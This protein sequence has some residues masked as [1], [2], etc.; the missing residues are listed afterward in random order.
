[1]K[2]DNFSGGFDLI[3][4]NIKGS[5][6]FVFFKSGSSFFKTFLE[7][8]KH[9]TYFLVDVTNKI[10]GVYGGFERF[11]VEFSNFVVP[12]IRFFSS[13]TSVINISNI[14]SGL[15]TLWNGNTL[16][17]DLLE[18]FVYGLSFE[19]MFVFSKFTGVFTF[20]LS[21]DWSFT[22]SF[23]SSKFSS[24]DINSI[25]SVLVFFELHNEKLVGLTS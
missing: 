21:E 18:E 4:S 23:T 12:M 14:V 11:S 24:K 2:C 3:F 10:G 20:N 8:V 7:S 5:L 17:L 19:H 9:G 15:S 25:K 6:D 16:R 1:M 13:G 22:S